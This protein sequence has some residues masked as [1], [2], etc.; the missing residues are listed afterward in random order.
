MERPTTD[1]GLIAELNDLL[2]LDHDAVQ[3]YTLAIKELSSE[4]HQQ[5]IREFRSDHERHIGELIALIEESGGV[6]LP[7]PHESGMFKLALQGL[8]GL[9][10]DVAV[11]RAFR[12]NE[13][14]V[15]DKYRRRAVRQ[16]P[17][18]VAAM[19]QRAAADE[20]RH[21]EWVEATLRSLGHDVGE[22][23]DRA[24]RLHQRLADAMESTERGAM[25][26]FESTRRV[27]RERPI[28]T[29]AG[30][31]ALVVGAGA[32]TRRMMR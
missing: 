22:F 29:I 14:Q 24:G 19:I 17:E 32:L 27:V 6:A 2:R 15:R 21:F 9:G 18:D 5:Q 23:E 11:L 28:V 3:A 16:E 20:E 4:S 10:D 26:A 25:R 8:A 30:F 12:S 13:R 31:A 1:A 7:L